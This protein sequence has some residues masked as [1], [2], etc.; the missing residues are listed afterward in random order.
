MGML[1][2]ALGSRP[3]CSLVLKCLIQEL[4][5]FPT[6][7]FLISITKHD[8]CP[9]RL[10]AQLIINTKLMLKVFANIASH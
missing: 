7:I 4:F 6:E 2:G 10:I 3:L 8:K 5:W 9:K 1:Y